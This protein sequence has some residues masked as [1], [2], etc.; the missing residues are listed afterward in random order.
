MW[1]WTAF[2]FFFSWNSIRI[3]IRNSCDVFFKILQNLLM[4]KKISTLDPFS[5][6]IDLLGNLER[7]LHWLPAP[8]NNQYYIRSKI[9]LMFPIFLVLIILLKFN[10]SRYPN[11]WYY[12]VLNYEKSCPISIVRNVSKKYLLKFGTWI[13]KHDIQFSQPLKLHT[14]QIP[15]ILLLWMWT[16]PILLKCNY[17]GKIFSSF[18]SNQYFKT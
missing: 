9:S 15:K 1:H 12:I 6:A 13:E 17:Y 18:H 10:F 3:R 4:M 11:N 5:R 14:A 16:L 8:P 7:Q 2:F